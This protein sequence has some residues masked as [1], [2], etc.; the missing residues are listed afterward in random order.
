MK[1]RHRGRVMAA[2]EFC[3]NKDNGDV[4]LIKP[5]DNVSLSSAGL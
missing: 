4:D 2:A 1:C 5:L 3:E